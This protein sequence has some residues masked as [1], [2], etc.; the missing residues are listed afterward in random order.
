[1]ATS[2]EY[3]LPITGKSHNDLR[4]STSGYDD[5][6]FSWRLSNSSTG[7]INW[8]VY[9]RSGQHG[10]I[11]SSSSK[12]LTVAIN[13]ETV[14]NSNVS[15]G[16]AANMSNPG[17]YLC[18]GTKIVGFNSFI[19]SLQINLSG[20]TWHPYQGNA[21]K[22]GITSGSASFIVTG[23]TTTDKSTP[24][25]INVGNI[26]R[27]EAPVTFENTIYINST[28]TTSNGASAELSLQDSY[29]N[30]YKRENG[31]DQ[32]VV[33]NKFKSLDTQKNITTQFQSLTPNTP[34]L[35]KIYI[36]NNGT[37]GSNTFEYTSNVFYTKSIYPPSKPNNVNISCN[38][39]EP[40]SDSE[41]ILSWS[42]PTD[43]GYSGGISTI[44][45]TRIFN[46]LRFVIDNIYCNTEKLLSSSEL[47]TFAW[48]TE[49]T[50]LN[51]T[52]L[53]IKQDND[54][55]NFYWDDLDTPFYTKS[56]Y[57]LP[58]DSTLWFS[59]SAQRVYEDRFGI[60]SYSPLSLN[61]TLVTSNVVGPIQDQ[62]K[63]FV[64]VNGQWKQGKVF[65]NVNNSWKKAKS[66]FSKVNNQWLKQKNE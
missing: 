9:L 10:E 19:V 1:M 42:N 61:D 30:L 28:G 21:F 31:Y 34:Y 57:S 53:R 35:V 51:H 25:S 20:I 55:L 8:S 50:G 7:E 6:Y 24:P 48:T 22:L 47:S 59:I 49:T 66:V 38:T 26:I 4:P 27:D 37:D 44:E 23:A 32:L 46:V 40:E 13:G 5:L 41:Y 45:G 18:S 39:D 14:Y 60:Q 63:V 15:V 3:I 43:L 62:A 54:D 17:K 52:S 29:I 56:N 16:I 65:V 11:Q 58:D 33:E 36:K 12:P 2:G 64:L